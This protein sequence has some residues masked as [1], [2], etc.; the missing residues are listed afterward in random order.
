MPW[1]IAD[2]FKLKFDEGVDKLME[3][4][5]EVTIDGRLNPTHLF[6]EINKINQDVDGLIY[7]ADGLAMAAA[8]CDACYPNTPQYST[9]CYSDILLEG[10]V[11]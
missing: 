8:V 5:E 3:G 2:N 7:C 11:T 9:V 1:E 6:Y 4:K 10:I